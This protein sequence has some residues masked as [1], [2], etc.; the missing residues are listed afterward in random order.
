MRYD[1]MQPLVEFAHSCAWFDAQRLSQLFTK[2]CVL[3]ACR[4]VATECH[5][6]SKACDQCVFVERVGGQQAFRQCDHA[7]RRELRQ[8]G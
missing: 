7:F 4:A 6:R 8:H 3:L 1:P 2:R 5:E